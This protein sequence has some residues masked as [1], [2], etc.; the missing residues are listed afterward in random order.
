MLLVFFI[1]L[2]IILLIV[3][4][5][6]E[7]EIEDFEYSNYE[8]QISDK[9]MIKFKI[10]I[11]N[12]IKILQIGLNKQKIKRIYSKKRLEK[13]N[14]KRL[15][16]K[17]PKSNKEKIKIL[18]IIKLKKVNLYLQIGTQDVMFTTI[19]IP[20]FTTILSIIFAKTSNPQKC[21]Y[22][23]QPIYIDK[24]IY[25]ISLNCIISIKMIHIINIMWK[26]LRKRDDIN[27][28][29]SNPRTYEYSYGQH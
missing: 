5:R 16:Q 10:F 27:E 20:M 13:I 28:R 2:I 22:K 14:A 4:L 18:E 3:S 6:F 8:K 11:L 19:F 17:L 24:N 29:T 15:I 21:F 9:L 12:N 26:V 23:L 1:F 25:K 7:I